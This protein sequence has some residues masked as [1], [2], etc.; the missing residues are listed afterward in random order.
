MAQRESGYARQERDLYET[1][2]WVT[3]ALIRGCL[4]EWDLRMVRLAIPSPTIWEPAAGGGQIAQALDASGFRVHAT[5]LAGRNGSPLTQD[6]LSLLEAPPEIRAIVTNPPYAL[7][8]EFIEQALDMMEMRRGLVAML[9]K[10]DF[11]SACTRAKL[12]AD[13]KAWGRKLVL[14]RR[15]VW[16]DKPPEPGK[17][18]STPSENHAWFVWDWGRR[19]GPP[20]IGYDFARERAS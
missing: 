18:K 14:T 7:A 1:P 6:F 2:A 3:K 12:F 15:I 13:C 9:L 20:T 8:T 11:D 4:H 19:P 16:F 17:R 5:D 10:V